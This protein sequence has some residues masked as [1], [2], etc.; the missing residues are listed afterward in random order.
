MKKL[1]PILI[2]VA[3]VIGYSAGP[4]WSA[5]ESSDAN[6]EWDILLSGQGEGPPTAPGMLGPGPGDG[7]G[8]GPGERGHLPGHHPDAGT[9]A[10]RRRD[11]GER[12]RERGRERGPRSGPERRG[13][14]TGAAV[15]SEEL[16]TFLGE[17]EPT[18][19]AKLTEL[20]TAEPEKYERRIP[21]LGRVYG[22]V[23]KQMERDEAMGKLSLQKIRL[24]L[25]VKSA[26]RQ[27]KDAGSDAGD[28]S[29]AQ[30]QLTQRTGE[31]FDVIVAQ[32]SLRVQEMQ[33]RVESWT[34]KAEESDDQDAEAK[35]RRKKSARRGKWLVKR[36]EQQQEQLEL[37]KNNRQQIVSRHVEDLLGSQ[38]P[39]PWGR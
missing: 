1:L 22:P 2:V 10:S 14:G 27:I 31:L 26:V 15:A 5:T 19:A 7:I 16:L 21:M 17:Y 39:F 32:E 34:T 25:Q 35:P 13:R 29:S 8:P 9:R 30:E 6:S 38:R 28:A 3:V 11:E 37:W 4:G 24:N 23:I 20:K 36:L 12:G 33:K 18:L